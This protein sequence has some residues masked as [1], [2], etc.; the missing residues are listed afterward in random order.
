MKKMAFLFGINRY[1]PPLVDLKYAR[2]DA[3]AVAEVLKKCYEFSDD[4]VVL[5]TC[6]QGVRPFTKHNILRCFDP[7]ILRCSEWKEALDLLIVGFWGHGVWRDGK[8][9]LCPM[10]T[11]LEHVESLALSLQELR[12]A[13]RKIPAKNV[14]IIL[15]CCQSRIDSRDGEAPALEPRARDIVMQTFAPK[16]LDLGG[17]TVSQTVAILNSC[18]EGERAYEWG[19]KSHGFFTHYLLEAFRRGETRVS[20]IFTYVQEQTWRSTARLQK[21]QKPFFECMG[22]PEIFLPARVGTPPLPPVSVVSLADTPMPDIPEIELPDQ[23]AQ[24]ESALL[25]N[26]EA[27]RKRHSDLHEK[28]QEVLVDYHETSERALS[29]A[30]PIVSNGALYFGECEKLRKLYESQIQA[31]RAEGAREEGPK[32]QAVQRKLDAL[33]MCP[34]ESEVTRPPTTVEQVCRLMPMLL[35]SR[36]GERF[37]K[38]IKGVEYAFRWCPAGEFMMGEPGYFGNLWGLIGDVKL[39]RV[40]LSQGFWMLE[41][42]VTQRMW[43]SVMGNNPS[44]FKGA[45]LPVECVSWNDCVNFCENI[46]ELSG[47]K[48]QLPTEAQWEYACRAGT[49][50]GYAGK[51]GSMG[52]YD[53]NSGSRTHEVKTKRPNAW[54]LYDMHGNVWEWCSDWYGADYYDRSPTSDPKGPPS[55]SSRVNRGGSWGSNAE[56]CRSANRG[57]I[58][59]TDSYYNVGF[60]LLF[61]PPSS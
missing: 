27:L 34:C 59:P 39:H 46:S 16:K 6:E 47:L 45:N 58:A 13:I 36:A 57:S 52:W 35:G 38:M 29:V 5:A 3:E 49:T 17:E 10:G 42:Q 14:C 30:R 2:Q 21:N 41:T 32:F 56:D 55:G 12:D 51:L 50:G 7:E 24:T 19:E 1:S 60:R 20:E 26:L 25:A 8:R 18:S 15:D 54:G 31:M 9:Y 43:E 4:D 61:V 22:K 53:S 44:E 48:I 28:Y 40:A 37:E 33:L 23:T 11:M